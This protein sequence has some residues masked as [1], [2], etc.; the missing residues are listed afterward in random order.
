MRTMGR[1]FI[2]K[3]TIFAKKHVNVTLTKRKNSKYQQT[4]K[5]DGGIRKHGRVLVQVV[6][7][8]SSKFEV[9]SSNPS[10]TKKPKTK[11]KNKKQEL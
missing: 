2:I 6:E 1:S 9:L 3:I 8:L 11:T 10:A 4:P 7:Y 5:F